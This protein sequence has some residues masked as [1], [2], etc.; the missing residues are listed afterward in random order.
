MFRKIKLLGA[1]SALITPL[2]VYA[3]EL[4]DYTTVDSFYQQA[5]V[6]GQ[7]NLKS[8]NQPQ[9]S[10]NGNLLGN[11]DVTY[12][13]L[14]FV[15]NI[16]S[17]GA[18]AF[19]RGQDK[20]SSTEKGYNLIMHGDADKYFSTD[21]LL[22][23]YGSFDL[24]YRKLEGIDDADDPFVKVGGGAGYGRV[25]NATPLAEVLRVVEELRR[26]NL[27][28][29]EPSDQTYLDMATVVAREEEYKSKFGFVD[30]KMYWIDELEKILQKAGVLKNNT[31]GTIGIIKTQDVLINERISIRK[32]GWIAKAGVG[33]IASDYSGN[34]SDPSLDASFEYA[35]PFSYELQLI[36]LMRYSTLLST[37]ITHHLTNRLSVT[38]QLADR[39][40]WEN[41]W[42]LD[43]ILPTADNE[44]DNITNQLTSSFRYYISNL[45][46]ANATLTLKKQDD[47][48]DTSSNNND[49]VSSLFVGVRYR[50][51]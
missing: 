10:Y 41:A 23:G 27:L 46:D 12:S 36:N 3:I 8:G 11:Y 16:T 45:I 31:L 7:F 6:T 39:I 26:Y 38:Y 30:Y 22:L 17:S 32:H 9:T 20:D 40:D 25:I 43:M 1:A 2:S 35:Y 50:L 51:R 47:K 28:A 24:G 44:K 37:D 14:P 21:S 18:L 48:N 34:S 29:K 49:V 15:W 42:D 33:Y 4:T 19:N 13:T 5:F